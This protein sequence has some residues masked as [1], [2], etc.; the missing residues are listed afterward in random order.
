MGPEVESRLD[1][2][3]KM[4]R[5]AVVSWMTVQNAVDSHLSP[6]E[7]IDDGA[8]GVRAPKDCWRRAG[9][10]SGESK[11]RNAPAK[12]AL[13]QYRDVLGRTGGGRHKAS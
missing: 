13:K 8:S 9:L 2:T 1:K 5:L 12:H 10:R 6:A 4:A 3:K 11:R 7:L